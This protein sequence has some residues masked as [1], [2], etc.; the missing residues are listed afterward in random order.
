MFNTK[1][2]HLYFIT[3]LND[4]ILSIWNVRP[5]FGSIS[6]IFELEPWNLIVKPGSF[7]CVVTATKN[8]DISTNEVDEVR[9]TKINAIETGKTYVSYYYDPPYSNIK[10]QWTGENAGIALSFTV[11]HDPK[12]NGTTPRPILSATTETV[13][14][15]TFGS[16]DEGIFNES[17]PLNSMNVFNWEDVSDREGHIITINIRFCSLF[18]LENTLDGHLWFF[19]TDIAGFVYRKY[20][21]IPSTT[22]FTQSFPILKRD[23]LIE[24]GQFLSVG[25]FSR[26]F[27]ENIT[28][29]L[30]TTGHAYSGQ[31]ADSINVFETNT[32]WAGSEFGIAFSYVV[33][34]DSF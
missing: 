10:S 1:D 33:L 20:S 5:A 31:L 14:E 28:V 27:S 15:F 24:R 25:I 2:N 4:S 17:L 21:V 32:K 23:F 22:L 8:I 18:R 34:I 19:I 7:L 30:R 11:T 13:S 26:G 12:W 9:L 6:L 16:I 3:I 29:C